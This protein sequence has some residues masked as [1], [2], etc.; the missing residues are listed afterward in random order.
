[1]RMAVVGHG[2]ALSEA[3]RTLARTLM[4]RTLRRLW[5]HT[6]EMEFSKGGLIKP[7]SPMNFLAHRADEAFAACTRR[8]Y[9]TILH[10]GQ[11]R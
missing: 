5:R 11:A 4:G 10:V 3:P 6:P 1:M 2:C 8:A 7:P 9:L